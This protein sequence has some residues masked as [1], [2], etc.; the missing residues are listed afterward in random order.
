MP[1]SNGVYRGIVNS[2]RILG[3]ILFILFTLNFTVFNVIQIY[4]KKT[5]FWV[6]IQKF[7]LPKL[8]IES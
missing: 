1:F 8:K 3:R 5:N 7:L 6:T 2:R 4:S